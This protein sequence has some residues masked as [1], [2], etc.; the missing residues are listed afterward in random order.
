MLASPSLQIHTQFHHNDGWQNHFRLLNKRPRQCP[1]V[2]D[3]LQP[4]QDMTHKYSLSQHIK[5]ALQR[6]CPGESAVPGR[7]EF[8]RHLV[9]RA[10]VGTQE[11][12]PEA[13]LQAKHAIEHAPRRVPFSKERVKHVRCCAAYKDPA[14]TGAKAC[15]MGRWHLH[16]QLGRSGISSGGKCKPPKSWLARNCRKL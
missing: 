6:A 3:Q 2:L 12:S 9:L 5:P 8:H 4:N 14:G 10:R 16:Q 13:A 15:T 7:L 11:H 1:T